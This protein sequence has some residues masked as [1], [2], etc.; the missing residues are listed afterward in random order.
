MF[1]LQEKK[2]RMIEMTQLDQLQEAN[3]EALHNLHDERRKKAK[4]IKSFTF[5]C[6]TV[7]VVKSILV[8]GLVQM[9]ICTI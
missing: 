7:N 4:V 9:I 2:T 8:F 3:R 1:D 5:L 6:R